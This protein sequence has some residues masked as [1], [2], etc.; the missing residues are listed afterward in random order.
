MHCE[1]HNMEMQLRTNKNTGEK[2]WSHKW[3]D[4]WCNKPFVANAPSAPTVTHD[5]EKNAQNRRKY[6]LELATHTP[7]IM[8]KEEAIA[9]AKEYEQYMLNG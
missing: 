4:G 7:G 5:P 6:C 3:G 9:A 2:F 8:S 1:E